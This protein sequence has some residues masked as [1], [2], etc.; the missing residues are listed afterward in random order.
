MIYLDYSATTPVDT[1]VREA[2]MPYLDTLFGN[3]S[4]RSHLYGW[5]AQEAVEAAQK[6]IADWLGVSSDEIIFTS[7]ATESINMALRGYFLRYREENPHFITAPT[8]H[9]AVLETLS[10]LE[11]I[12]GLEVDY[13]PVDGHGRVRP[14][15]VLHAVK[16]NTRMV[17]LMWG[18]NETGVLHPLADIA[19]ICRS[20]EI[21]L[22]SDA[23]QAAGKIT[24]RPRDVG[25]DMMALSSHKMYGPKGMGILYVRRG[26]DIHPLIT[27]GGQQKGRRAGTLNVPSI[28]GMA[29]AVEI[30][31]QESAEE[32]RRLERLRDAIELQLVERIEGL[33]VHGG[34][35]ARLPHITKVA[36]SA[37]SACNAAEIRPSHVLKAMGLSDEEALSSIRISVGRFTTEEQITM[38]VEVELVIARE[39]THNFKGAH[40]FGDLGRGG[41]H[42]FKGFALSN[43]IAKAKVAAIRT[44]R[45]SDEVSYAGS[46]QKTLGT[47]SHGLADVDHLAQSACDQ[48]C[49]YV[50]AI[51]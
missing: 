23:T 45:G 5:Q 14:E 15:D 39:L 22:M 11:E 31:I 24:L 27:G 38:A 34:A 10:Y 29:K 49:L 6:R 12:H 19:E 36:L 44:R 26:V 18:N 32:S 20:R 13:L 42:L 30:L 1:R 47:G 41:Q 50:F 3:P 4:S 28:V 51:T 25:V 17:I 21:V 33:T 37:G 43:L 16:E 40:A 35:A 2:M 8:E 9:K 48:Q 7:G 46:A